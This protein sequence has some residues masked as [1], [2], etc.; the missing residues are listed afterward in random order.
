MNIS[1]QES[2]I[3]TNR[4]FVGKFN[5]NEIEE[6]LHNRKHCFPRTLVFIASTPAT[7]YA[8]EKSFGSKDLQFRNFTNFE[9]M[10]KI[11]ADRTSDIVVLIDQFASA[12]REN[13]AKLLRKKSPEHVQIIIWDE[14]S[15]DHLITSIKSSLSHIDQNNTKELVVEKIIDSRRTFSKQLPLSDS[16]RTTPMMGEDEL[17]NHLNRELKGNLSHSPEKVLAKSIEIIKELK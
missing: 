17:R 3:A 1:N 7:M 9:S 11:G 5:W 14:S 10:L 6:S 2:K 15:I 13:F 4:S 8:C 12:S 16:P